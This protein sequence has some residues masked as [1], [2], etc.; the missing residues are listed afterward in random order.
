MQIVYQT[1]KIQNSEVDI[2]LPLVIGH[3]IEVNKVGNY[4]KSMTVAELVVLDVA[5]KEA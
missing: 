5:R 3:I 1:H 4:T 2:Y